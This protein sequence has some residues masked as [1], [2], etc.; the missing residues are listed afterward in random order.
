MMDHKATR[1][2]DP[3]DGDD[4]IDALRRLQK[5]PTSVIENA[6]ISAELDRLNLVRPVGVGRVITPKGENLL[7][8]RSARKRSAKP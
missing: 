5:D 8:G 3:R 6:F 4:L 1:A 2:S 7:A